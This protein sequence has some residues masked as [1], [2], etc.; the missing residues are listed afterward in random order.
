[1][2]KLFFAFLFTQSMLF[3]CALCVYYSPLTQVSLNVKSNDEMIHS[4]DFKWELSKE[5]TEQL[6]EIYDTN[7]NQK[8]DYEELDLIQTALIDYAKPKNFMTHISYD[9]KS[10]SNEYKR[11]KASKYKTYIQQNVL[12]FH[13]T[14]ELNEP[15]KANHHLNIYVNDDENYFILL[16]NKSF[17]VFKNKVKIHKHIANKQRVVFSIDAKTVLSKEFV[18]ISNETSLTQSKEIAKESLLESFTQKLKENL[19]KVKQGEPLALLLL[20]V[21]SFGYG[22][23]HALGP[24]HGKALAF[25]YF[26]SHKSSFFK[27]FIIALASSFIHIVSALILV[28]M[29]IF[30][31]KSFLNNFVNDTVYWLSVLSAIMIMLL[32]LYLLI[33]KLKKQSCGC[34]SCGAHN[35]KKNDLYFVLTAGLIPCAGT[36]IL[37][38]YAFVL[39]TYWAVFLASI[40]IS[41]GMAVVVFAASFMG[42]SV[43]K[44]SQKSHKITQILEIISPIVMF[45]LGVLLLASVV[46]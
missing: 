24:G 22:M 39:K 14:L 41:L 33:M 28:L 2:I 32:A 31:L 37:F 40:F 19:Q 25:S 35:N 23:V 17:L 3:S 1:M 21:V 8:I 34:S 16:L 5:F 13:F 36:V 20:L 43:H 38:I 45:L 30:I 27:A 15:I 9:E 11:Y 46:L 18:E 4:I 6:L 29:S 10:D 12:F 7:L 26:S 42:V 44:V